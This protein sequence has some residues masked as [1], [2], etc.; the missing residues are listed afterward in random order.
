M[1]LQSLHL[2]LEMCPILEFA[3]YTIKKGT[4]P[5][6]HLIEGPVGAG[7]STL[8]AQLSKEHTAPHLNLDD[9]MATLFRP[10]RPDDRV[11]EWY[12]ERKHRCFE[13]IWKVTQSLLAADCD[14]VLELG[15]IQRQSRQAFYD[16]V[17]AAGY[18]IMVY[19]LDIPRDIRRER[20]RKRNQTKGET[21]S[22]EVPDH[23]FE[24]A[25]DLWEP[26]DDI[27]CT[28]REI[29]IISGQ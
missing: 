16:R 21:Y 19:V 25:S 27:E 15:L 29:R 11:L 6:I 2:T 23:I 9:W 7:K 10:D 28:D 1:L 8:A 22:M 26:P 24:F 13:Q 18:S 12:V 14:V 5:H 20:V 3:S 17:D 4:M